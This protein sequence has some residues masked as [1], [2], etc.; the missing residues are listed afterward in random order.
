MSQWRHEHVVSDYIQLSFSPDLYQ[1][2]HYLVPAGTW[3]KSILHIPR[4]FVGRYLLNMN[5][6]CDWFSETKVI[7]ANPA[8]II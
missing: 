2:D 6:F 8:V 5:K 7:S 3:Q 1:I 4:I